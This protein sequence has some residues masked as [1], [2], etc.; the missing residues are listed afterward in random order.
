MSLTLA[1]R[2]AVVVAVA[3]PFLIGATSSPSS[4]YFNQAWAAGG[5][6]LLL[7]GLGGRCTGE[8]D[9]ARG[10]T[11]ALVV[12]AMALFILAGLT[13]PTPNTRIAIGMPSGIA[14]IAPTNTA[15]ST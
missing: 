4:T 12:A 13:G 11:L 7:W 14:K 15:P 3:T 9:A 6:G 5:W 1:S 8:A 2:A 10:R